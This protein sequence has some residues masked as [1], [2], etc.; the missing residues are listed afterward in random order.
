LEK[1]PEKKITDLFS[2]SE[3]RARCQ[4]LIEERHRSDLLR[5]YGVEPR[6]R[7]LLT[8]PAGNGKTSLAEGIAEA[9]MTPLT[10]VRYE[11]LFNAPL[12]ETR[13]RLRQ[14]FN[15][16]I[17]QHCVLFFDD[18]ETFGPFEAPFDPA[19]QKK[20]L[21]SLILQIAALPSF[22]VAIAATNNEDLLD[23]ALLRHFQIRLT[24]P[25]PT[26]KDPRAMFERFAIRA[27]FNF[28]LELSNLASA[29]LAEVSRTRRSSL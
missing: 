28:G 12:S 11:N 14:L 2:P 18:L 23:P 19:A 22:V 6:S 9:L 24:M 7:V 29:F 16:A 10:V 15:Y 25:A 21:S 1:I 8:G 17:K 3:V 26:V 27:R 13:P 20:A 4:E 5:S